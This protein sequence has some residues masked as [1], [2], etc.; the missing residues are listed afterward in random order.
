MK[1]NILIIAIAFALASLFTSCDRKVE[2]QS[3]S[4]V[5]FES[6][7]FSVSEAAGKL[8]IPVSIYNPID[9]AVNVIVRVNSDTAVEGEDFRVVSPVN[10]VLAF[11]R[12]ETSK[13]I[14]IELIYDKEMT[15]SKHFEVVIESPDPAFIVGNHNTVSCKIKDK[16]HPLEMF[17][18]DWVGSVNAIDPGSGATTATQ[19]NVTIAEDEYDETY[20]KLRIHNFDP[21]AVNMAKVYTLKATVDDEK[22][23]ITIAN[24]Q[25]LAYD[26]IYATYYVFY[27][28]K[29]SAQG[30]E[31]ADA[32]V[33][34][35][36]DQEKETLTISSG[37]GSLFTYSDGNEYLG[38][39]Y[40]GGAVLKKK[41]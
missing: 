16:E 22:T 31:F 36:Y 17:I 7:S 14:D 1:K 5:T 30:I 37:Y 41:E 34:L 27:G 3:Q 29:V 10:K 13:N 24:E 23:K 19:L 20:K 26:D 28:F 18:G 8:S 38:S 32:P 21:V 35:L 11:D 33:S 9:K 2:F 12:G 39:V 40:E 15:G 6:V 25:P 4:F